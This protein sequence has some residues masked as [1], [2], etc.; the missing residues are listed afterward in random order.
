MGRGASTRSCPRNQSELDDSRP[1]G[2]DGGGG[3]PKPPSQAGSVE[4]AQRPTLEAVEQ[5]KSKG[6]NRK[7]AG[8]PE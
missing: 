3:A 2:H 7:K 1:T 4:A 6:G 5:R 8:R